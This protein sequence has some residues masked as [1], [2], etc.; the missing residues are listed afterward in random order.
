MSF[1]SFSLV[2]GC[3][4]LFNALSISAADKTVPVDVV[5]VV[6]APVY[7]DVPLTGSVESRRTSR[8]SPQLAGYV[9]EVLVDESDM[10]SGGDALIRLDSVMAEIELERIRAE[11][12][13]SE[14]RLAEAKRQRNEAAELVEKKHIPSTDYEARTSEVAIAEAALQRL[15]AN[16]EHQREVLRRHTVRAPFDGV[17]GEKLVEAGQWV[18]TGSGLFQLV[19]MDVLR[20]DIPVPQYYFGRIHIGTPASVRFDALP[21]Y[22]LEGTITMKIPISSESARTFPV[23]IEIRNEDGRIAPGMSAR[24]RLRL[25][26]SGQEEALLLPRDA[27]VRKPDG[28]STIW[29][30]DGEGEETPTARSIPVQTGRAFHSNVEITEGGVEAGDRV[31]VRGNEILEPGQA[32]RIHREVEMEF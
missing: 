24:V 26:D 27:I 29:V 31:V 8:L 11:I 30:V 20:V 13:E 16:L 1:H 32:V 23:R 19:E 4:F 14:A 2:A 6:R 7:D 22:S 9:A 12:R 15:Q 21:D 17:I 28:T 25:E 5:E 18:E 10:V 3:L